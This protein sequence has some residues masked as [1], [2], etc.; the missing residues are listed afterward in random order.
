MRSVVST[1]NLTHCLSATFF[2]AKV[3]HHHAVQQCE[4][5]PAAYVRHLSGPSVRREAAEEKRE[6]KREVQQVK[7]VFQSLLWR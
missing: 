5:P 6:I 3:G 4:A 1:T 7:I 2:I